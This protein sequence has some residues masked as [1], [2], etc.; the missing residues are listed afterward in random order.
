V[1]SLRTLSKLLK[2]YPMKFDGEEQ[3][4]QNEELL[5]SNAAHVNVDG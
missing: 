5:Q 3:E 4:H 1:H 2:N